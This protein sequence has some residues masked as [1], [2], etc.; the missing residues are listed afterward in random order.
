MAEIYR[1]LNN[2]PLS[3]TYYDLAMKSI[4]DGGFKYFRPN[5]KEV[6][7]GLAKLYEQL[8]DYKNSYKY[9]TLFIAMNDSLQ[10]EDVIS[11]INR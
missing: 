2:I 10:N 7:E 11:Q 3:F 4:N 5:A 1:K 8:K 6:Y 9:Q